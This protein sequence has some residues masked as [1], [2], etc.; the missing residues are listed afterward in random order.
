MRELGNHL[1]C[2]LIQLPPQFRANNERLD[3]FL[4]YSVRRAKV[5]KMKFDIAVEFRHETWFSEDTYKI[6]RKYKVAFVMGDSSVWPKER[7]FTADYSYVRFHGPAK[8]FASSYSEKQLEEWAL[9]MKSQIKIKK[10][11]CYFNNDQSARAIDNAK[12]LQ[13]ILK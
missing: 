4:E 5:L 6:L 11:Y 10:Y 7:A 1:G 12:Y 2:L 3:E 13:K 9:F 8:V